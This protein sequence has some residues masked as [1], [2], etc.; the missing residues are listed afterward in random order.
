MIAPTEIM[1]D[2]CLNANR[3]TKRDSSVRYLAVSYSFPN[4][5]LCET[6][7][8]VLYTSSEM[9]HLGMRRRK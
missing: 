1:D 8:P 3:E 7:S 4:M 6:V 9:S 5:S 2:E